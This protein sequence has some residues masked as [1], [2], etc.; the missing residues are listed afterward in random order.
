MTI[1]VDWGNSQQTVM[2]YAIT[3]KWTWLELEAALQ[4]SIIS[5]LESTSAVH[6]IYDMTYSQPLPEDS[7]DFWR[8]AIR[9]MP[10]N[11]GHLVFVGGGNNVPPLLKVLERIDP[12][13]ADRLHTVDSLNQAHKLLQFLEA[14]NGV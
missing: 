10:E 4:H 11:R 8:N 3:G 12:A 6:E 1:S 14:K 5:T 9:V 13:Y 7:L 2:Q